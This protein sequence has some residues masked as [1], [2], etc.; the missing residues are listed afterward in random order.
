MNVLK[1]IAAI[2]AALVLSACNSDKCKDVTCQNGGTC[3]DGN[4]KCPVAFE[5]SKCEIESRAK[6]LNN[7]QA[8]V[9]KANETCSGDTNR[10]VYT[11][12]ISPAAAKNQIILGNIGNFEITQNPTATMTSSTAFEFGKKDIDIF[13]GTGNLAG[14]TLTVNTFYKPSGSPTYISCTATLTRQ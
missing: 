12:T 11:V 5:G 7:G 1:L 8:A 9:W 13:Y 14:N 3:T 2:V 10:Y 4:C 6:F